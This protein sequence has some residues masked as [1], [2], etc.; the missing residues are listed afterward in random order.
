MEAAINLVV[1][2]ILGKWLGTIGVF[3]GTTVSIVT[4]SLW[5]EPYMLYKHKLNCSAKT[6]FVRYALYGTVTTAV[7]ICAE[8]LCRRITG[9]LFEM[10]VLRLVCCFGITN[11]VYFML[12]YR[13][14][15]F[16]L[17]KA[18]ALG[19]IKNIINNRK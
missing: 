15:E 3:I 10:C 19:I 18:K 5:V 4:T 9:T 16:R 14:K 8:L 13:T 1:S 12:Y 6:Y 7:W 11:L 17:L 2:L